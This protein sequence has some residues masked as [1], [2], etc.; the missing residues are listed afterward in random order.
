MNSKPARQIEPELAA[1][2]L[3][4]SADTVMVI[5]P[6]GHMTIVSTSMSNVLGH[7]DYYWEGRHIGDMIHPGD[8]DAFCA[9][10]ADDPHEPGRVRRDILRVRLLSEAGEWLLVEARGF[11]RIEHGDTVGSVVTFRDAAGLVGLTSATALADSTLIP[12]DPT[13]M[14]SIDNRRIIS[15]EILPGVLRSCASAQ[16]LCVF[17][18]RM[19]NFDAVSKDYGSRKADEAI[20]L[21][22]QAMILVVRPTDLVS[23][24]LDRRLV[25]AC[26]NLD[27]G[28]VDRVAARLRTACSEVKL[29]RGITIQLSIGYALSS[30]GDD[31]RQVLDFALDANQLDAAAPASAACA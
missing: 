22:A 4:A 14:A 23:R 12:S 20:L 1:K 25:V 30:G 13:R 27:P 18:L 7:P 3:E 29:G 28:A 17:A 21:A 2:I 8:V 10:L 5:A 15:S 11:T 16:H 31:L 9:L 24:A 6:S 19:T 26:P